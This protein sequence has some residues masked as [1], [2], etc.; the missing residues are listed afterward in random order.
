MGKFV[1]R[2]AAA[3]FLLALAAA[4]GYTYYRMFMNPVVKPEVVTS[5]RPERTGMSYTTGRTAYSPSSAEPAPGSPAPSP[6]VPAAAEERT[7]T[8]VVLDYDT[9]APMPGF[10]VLLLGEETDYFAEA[11]TGTRG[12]FAFQDIPVEAGD[13]F[14]LR[15]SSESW[16]MPDVPAMVGERVEL[17]P[18]AAAV[19]QGH[20]SV[21]SDPTSVREARVAAVVRWENHDVSFYCTSDARGDYRLAALPPGEVVSL[22]VFAPSCVPME[23]V[24]A[25]RPIKLRRRQAV[26]QNIALVPGVEITGTVTNA[27]GDPVA[28]ALVFLVPRGEE[29]DGERA[30]ELRDKFMYAA[31][32]DADGAFVLPPPPPGGEWDVCVTMNGYKDARK[33]YEGKKLSIVLEEA[34]GE[35][36]P[37]A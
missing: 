6:S 13:N 17:R 8:G 23:Y 29:P 32:T 21:P 14:V 36:E 18:V 5:V 28:G 2:A 12:E 24:P 10:V 9:G 33:K 7:V 1:R 19:L 3:L 34:E 27:D 31:T 20:V 16:Y 4:V 30:A 37:G 25:G 35:G 15:G 26:I 11:L 22:V